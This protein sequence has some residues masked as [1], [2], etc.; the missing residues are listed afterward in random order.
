[1]LMMSVSLRIA[2]NEVATAETGEAALAAL[3][4]AQPGVLVLD[5][6]LPGIG[7]REVLRQVRRH[8]TLRML[9][10]VVVSAHAGAPTINEMAE[11][12][13]DRYLTK[14]F[15]PRELVRVVATLPG[16]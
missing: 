1:A 7:G 4:Q 2:G 5:L 3:K 6:G 16:S 12:G 15:D 13:C 14:P 8:P 11:L 9:P 10:V